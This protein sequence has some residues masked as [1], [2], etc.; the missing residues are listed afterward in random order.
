MAT[1]SPN[2]NV[3]HRNLDIEENNTTQ[4]SFPD[5]KVH[6]NPTTQNHDI[7]K[8]HNDNNTHNVDAFP[9]DPSKEGFE[10]NSTHKQEGVK[11]VEAMTSVWSK[12][13]LWMLFGL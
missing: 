9:D 5:E 12:K 1:I 8:G 4:R 10:T 2:D 7:E 3:A 13:S 11:R 6:H